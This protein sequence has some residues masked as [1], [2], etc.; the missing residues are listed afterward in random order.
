MRRRAA[1]GRLRGRGRGRD[2]GAMYNIWYVWR[3][4]E[5]LGR[6]LVYHCSIRKYSTRGVFMV[7]LRGIQEIQ[8]V[9]H[10]QLSLFRLSYLSKLAYFFETCSPRP[11]KL[12]FSASCS[13][14]HSGRAMKM[15]ERASH[16]LIRASG[17]P[18]LPRK[19]EELLLALMHVAALIRLI[20]QALMQLSADAS[21]FVCNLHFSTS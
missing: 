13:R 17:S 16:Q 15:Y 3:I 21:I 10:K 6:R 12:A 9:A 2:R 4:L 1:R 20:L 14:T 18:L 5:I 8:M 11:H 7:P 19:S